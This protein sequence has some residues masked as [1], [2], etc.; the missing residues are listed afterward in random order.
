M[1][2]NRLSVDDPGPNSALM[3]WFTRAVRLVRAT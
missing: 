2:L 3:M 1:N